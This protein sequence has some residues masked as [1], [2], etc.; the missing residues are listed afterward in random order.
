[1]VSGGVLLIDD[2]GW[3]QGSKAAVDEFLEKTGARLLMLRMDEG[4]IAVKP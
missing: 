4:R 2:Y 1:L 3:W